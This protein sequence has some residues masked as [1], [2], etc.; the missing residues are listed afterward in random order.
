MYMPSRGKQVDFR[1]SLRNSSQHDLSVFVYHKLNP[2]NHRRIEVGHGKVKAALR[3]NL[4]QRVKVF[5][6][7]CARVHFP[8]VGGLLPR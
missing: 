4:S 5:R 2:L 7:G 8:L 6:P 3:V 1:R